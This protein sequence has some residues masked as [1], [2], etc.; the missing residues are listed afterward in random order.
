MTKS[1]TDRL[2]KTGD[3]GRL[4]GRGVVFGDVLGVG[5]GRVWWSGRLV[6]SFRWGSGFHIQGFR[7]GAVSVQLWA[8]GLGFRRCPEFGGPIFPARRGWGPD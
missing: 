7:G 8:L 5:S 4:R 1:N 2:G 6:G 3:L